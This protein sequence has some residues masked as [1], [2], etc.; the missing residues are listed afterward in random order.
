MAHLPWG[1]LSGDVLMEY[2]QPIGVKGN[3][4]VIQ[5]QKLPLYNNTPEIH[6]LPPCDMQ[7]KSQSICIFNYQ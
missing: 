3:K 1:N 2:T 4:A 7:K 5:L 6:W